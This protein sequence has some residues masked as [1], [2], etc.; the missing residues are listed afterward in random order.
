MIEREPV[1]NVGSID[2]VV[3]HAELKEL[4]TSSGFKFAF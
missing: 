4:R 1:A 3:I 2:D